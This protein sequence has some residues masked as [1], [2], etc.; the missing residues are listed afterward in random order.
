MS[1][2]VTLEWIGQHIRALQPQQRTLSEKLD[3]L[4]GAM[5]LTVTHQQLLEV[6]NLLV[7]RIDALETLMQTRFDGLEKH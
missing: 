4:Y 7:R 6:M 5:S 2:T 1:E 3:L